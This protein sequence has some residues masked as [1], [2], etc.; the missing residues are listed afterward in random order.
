MT[1][2]E[3]GE[4]ILSHYDAES[5]HSFETDRS[6][7]VFKRADNKKWFAATKNIG[8]RYL[9]INRTGRIDI[10]NV[11]LAPRIVSSLRERAGFMPAWKMNQNNWVTVLLDGSV[12]DEEIRALLDE[13]FKVAGIRP[14]GSGKRKRS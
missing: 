13:G 14:R 7:A 6:V 2:A 10:L 11:K 12:A 5:D 8:C 3:I 1:L 9:G 4:Y